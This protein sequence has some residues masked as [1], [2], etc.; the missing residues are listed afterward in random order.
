SAKPATRSMIVVSQT[1]QQRVP[2]EIFLSQKPP[3]RDNSPVKMKSAALTTAAIA[4][5]SSGVARAQTTIT[6]SMTAP[7]AAP[8]LHAPFTFSAKTSSPF[9]FAIPA[10]GQAPLTFSATG[11]PAGLAIA[12]GTGIITG[13]TPAAGSYPVAV[14]VMNG[15]GSATATYALVSGNTLS[16]T[17]P[18]GWNSY[19]SF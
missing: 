5:L 14:T 3:F 9:L 15:S 12:S 13:T 11:L 17:P 19:D 4:L 16:L 6:I 8:E 2:G 18:M 7:P 10:S 1:D